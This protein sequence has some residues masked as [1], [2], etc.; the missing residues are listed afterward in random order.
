MAQWSQ[1]R[2]HRKFILL[3]GTI[4]NPYDLPFPKMGV[5]NAPQDKL[6]VAFCHLANMIEYID[7][8]YQT[9]LQ[10]I[11]VCSV[12]CRVSYYESSNVAL[13]QITLSFD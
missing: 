7:K 10:G 9:I 6:R 13:C 4:G 12:L 3:T 11:A 8:I 1:W 2:A 5:P